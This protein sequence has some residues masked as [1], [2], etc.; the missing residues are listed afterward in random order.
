MKPRVTVARAQSPDG[1]PLELIEHDGSYVIMAD[2][3]LLMS[4]RMSHSEEELAR[5]ACE[6][7]PAGCRVLIGGLG[8]GYS[9]RATLDLISEDSEVIQA[10]LVSEVVD[11]NRGPLATFAS[12]PLGDDRVE[13]VIGD[14]GEVIQLAEE[15]FDA[16]ILDVDNGPAAIVNET[17]FWL[18]SDEGLETMRATL[19]DAGRL[20]IWSSEDE[21]GFTGRMRRAGFEAERHSVG[22]RKSGKGPRHV[23]FLGRVPAPRRSRR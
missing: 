9:L 15:P 19:T 21:R 5:I 16:I 8:C 14:V 23:V 1:T 2:G 17:N 10:E 12:N 18:Y 6:G 3:L 22:S 4:T 20:A 11:W 13:V 7:L